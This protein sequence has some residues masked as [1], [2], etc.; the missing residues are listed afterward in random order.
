VTGQRS[1]AQGEAAAPAR[2]KTREDEVRGPVEM[3][4]PTDTRGRD[5]AFDGLRGG[6]IICVM[7]YHSGLGW[8]SGGL[9]MIDAFFVLSGFLI[10]GLLI[11]EWGR[12]S[13]IRLR[14]FWARRARRLL[15][16]LLLLLAGIGL[17]AWLIAAPGERPAIRTNALFTLLYVGN[18]H[19]IFS[20]Q[21][22]FALSSNP[23][24]LLHTWTLA[25]EEQFY[26][27][28]PLIVLA[29]LHFTRSLRLLLVLAVALVIASVVWMA[30]LYHPGVDP[31]RLYYGTDTRAQNVLV[32]AVL[33]IALAMRPQR[34]SERVRRIM[35]VLPVLAFAAIIA[36]WFV[37]PSNPGL[38]YRGGFLF[39]DVWFALL[40]L[41]L[42]QAPQSPAARI[43][44]WRPLVYIGT[45]SYSL[46]L[47]HWPI[48]L[49]LT[50]ARTGLSGWN[51]FIVRSLV[52]GVIAAAST[53]WIENPIRLGTF[54]PWK[55]WTWTLTPV[56]VF[57]T[58]GVVFMATI[59]PVSAEPVS[60]AGS[61]TVG[62]SPIKFLMVGDSQAITLGNGLA[63][64][65]RT[66]GVKFKDYGQD[67]CGF[68]LDIR[69]SRRVLIREV[70][71]EIDI[72][73][74]CQHWQS[75]W[76]GLV[77]SERPSVVGILMGRGA[78]C[79]TYW[80]GH[81]VHVGETAWDDYLMVGMNLAVKVLSSRGAHVIFF[82]APY[83]SPT[84]GGDANGA[85]FPEDEP[86]RV[87]AYN[88]L[89]RKVASENPKT[90]TVFDL[91]KEFTVK[92]DVYTP[93][94]DGYTVRNPDGVHFT[95][96]A[97]ELTG[98]QLFPLVDRLALEGH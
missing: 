97:G 40:F 88:T 85:S 2:T 78:E 81:W 21:S 26:L 19:E 33:A 48:D 6:G 15:P 17:F 8:A 65:A 16:G 93:T 44:S 64:D 56:A 35:A 83:D 72:S 66:V 70:G 9:T 39:A 49:W 46:Y 27:V 51:L 92:K 71:Q 89:V 74:V 24:P 13:T 77:K 68:P 60:A 96:A 4:R 32:G 45:I 87:D 18:W 1:S 47:W 52:A 38:L 41:G 10:T 82:T 30:V 5:L 76:A 91:N 59:V 95:L 55:N 79:D 20:G 31:S 37:I 63:V 54:R 11:K 23:S 53:R 14:R 75:Y 12:S 34:V 67:S 36:E 3:G 94:I 90:V 86:G 62:P 42:V 29:V 7:A 84:A 25:I 73:S 98:R 61:S 69:S 50:A 28:W 80:D 22:Y 58:A 43:L 57:A